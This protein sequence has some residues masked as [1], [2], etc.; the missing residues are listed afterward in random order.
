MLIWQISPSFER[1]KME[2]FPFHYRNLLFNIITDYDLT[3]QEIRGILDYLFDAKA[4][5]ERGE[6]Q[7]PGSLFDIEIDR[8]QYVVDINGCEVIVYRRTE[9]KPDSI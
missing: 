2:V 3:F 8:V 1:S 6:N 9:L 5:D 4:F 7:E